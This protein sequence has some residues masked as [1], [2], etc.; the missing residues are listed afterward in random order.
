MTSRVLGKA[1][2]MALKVA[3][4]RILEDLLKVEAHRPRPEDSA[5]DRLSEK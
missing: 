2:G 4:A 3:A 1:S 5:L